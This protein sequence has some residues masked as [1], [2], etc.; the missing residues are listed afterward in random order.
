[1]KAAIVFYS[2]SGNTEYVAKCISEK[3]NADII[4]LIP[5]KE[6][7]NT[8]FKKFFWCGKSAVM[9]EKPALENYE[10]NA[11][12]YDTIIFGTPVWASCYTPPLRTFINENADKIKGKK[13]AA[14]TCFSGGGADKAIEKLKKSLDLEKFEAELILIDPKDKQNEENINRIDEFCKKIEG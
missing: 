2:M 9:G 4:R 6:Y 12:L 14:F 7:P 3:I 10:F 5:K 1:M 13:F 8:G 11:D